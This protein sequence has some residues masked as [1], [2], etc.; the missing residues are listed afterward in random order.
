MKVISLVVFG[1]PMG[2]Q[3][4]R[5]LKSGISFTP[6]KTVNYET[7]V[8]LTYGQLEDKCFFNGQ[9]WVRITAYYPISKSTSK[10]KS[11][12]MVDGF[13]RPTKKPDCDNVAKIICDALNGVAYRD[14]SQIVTCVIKK[15]YGEVPKVIIEIGEYEGG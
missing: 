14:D 4:A 10:L 11:K 3:R 2:K 15:Y 9:V 12:Q 1:N 5:I 13:I 8:K 7:L 6:D